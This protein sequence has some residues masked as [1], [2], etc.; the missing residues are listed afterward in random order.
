MKDVAEPHLRDKQAD[1]RKT[2]YCTDQVTTLRIILEQSL[3]WNSPLYVSFIDYERWHLTVWIGFWNSYEGMTCRV[4][5][6]Q[7][8][9]E[10]LQVQTEARQGCL[11]SPFFPFGD[12]LLKKTST[13]Q[14]RNGIQCTV[15][16]QQDDI[17]FAD[18]LLLFSHYPAINAGED[19]YHSRGLIIHKVKS[20]ILRD[21]VHQM[22]IFFALRNVFFE[23]S[24]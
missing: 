10:A 19:H 8:L 5:P 4:V 7:Q 11:L 23:H 6:G 14:E 17:D 21:C 1:F 16:S 13:A 18:D 3:E 15:W 20:R 2:S 22:W 12:R 9:T 24:V